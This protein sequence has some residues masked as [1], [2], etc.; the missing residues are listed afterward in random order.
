MAKKN[1][2]RAWRV[3]VVTLV[4]AGVAMM[5]GLAILLFGSVSGTEFSPTHF[6]SRRF[7]VH[8]IPW[9]QIQISP[10]RRTHS[11]T[12]T[13]RYLIGQSLIQRA[14]GPPQEWH[15][16]ELSRGG[17]SHSQADAKLLTDQ[18]ELYVY[19][20]NASTTSSEFWHNWSIDQPAKAKV[21]WPIIQKMA[22]REL[23]I[24]MPKMF[25]LAIDAKDELV[26]QQAIDDYLRGSYAEL[27]AEMRNNQR[28]ELA[29]QLLT[30]A[31]NDY[32]DDP[33]L[34]SLQ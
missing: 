28:R 30:E 17:L 29:A 33:R 23:Y 20:H 24:L 12:A 1:S 13:A 2:G 9:L 32:P 4:C 18:L 27:V 7:T 26:L 10:I 8:E 14:P 11:Q 25:S 22:L 19:R 15:V 16:V 31:L 34:R 6:E 21:L 5:L 3:F